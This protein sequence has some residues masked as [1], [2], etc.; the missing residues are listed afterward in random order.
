MQLIFTKACTSY[1][2]FSYNIFLLLFCWYAQNKH[3]MLQQAM[4]AHTDNRCIN[5]PILNI[6]SSLRCLVNATPR[7]LSLRNKAPVTF[8]EEGR[9]A[10]GP[11]L[12]AAKKIKI[13]M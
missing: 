5:L 6:S 13:L 4:K 8:V 2:L 9:W 12:K 10:P 7:P 3:K 11:V 1:F